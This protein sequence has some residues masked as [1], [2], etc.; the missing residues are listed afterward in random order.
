MTEEILNNNKEKIDKFYQG[1]L[2]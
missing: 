2:S 1:K